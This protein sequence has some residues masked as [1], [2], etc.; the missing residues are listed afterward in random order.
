MSQV[1]TPLHILRPPQLLHHHH[2]LCQD[3]P[4]KKI[5]AMFAKYD[6]IFPQYYERFDKQHE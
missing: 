1:K 3:I 6:R 4:L 5:Q 2:H